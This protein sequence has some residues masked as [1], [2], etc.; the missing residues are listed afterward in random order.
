MKK[1]VKTL[2]AA[3]LAI[4]VIG[5]CIGGFFVWRHKNST[6]GGEAALQIALDDAG[7][8]RSQVFDVDVDYDRDRYAAVYEVEFRSGALEYEYVI[9]AATG[10][11]LSAV[12]EP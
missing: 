1:S 2:L 11:I 6:I 12:S 7:L 3:V 5:G 4:L 10:E 9:A 8:V